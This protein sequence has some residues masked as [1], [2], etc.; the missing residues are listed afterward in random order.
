MSDSSRA[1]RRRTRRRDGCQDH[2]WQRVGAVRPAVI[3]G[4]RLW[5]HLAVIGNRVMLRSPVE[6][7]QFR[8]R[9]FR[10]VI[11]EQCMLGSMGR[12]ASAGGIAAMESFFSSLQKT[13]FNRRMWVA[14]VE[15]RLA[16][17][18]WTDRRTIVGV[19]NEGLE[20]H[21]SRVRVSVTKKWPTGC[22]NSNQAMGQLTPTNQTRSRPMCPPPEVQQPPERR[23]SS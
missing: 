20:G 19:A 8:S 7:R 22:R 23:Y 16:I 6:P 18:R 11:G 15:L 10:G 21:T 14:R 3:V 13:L 12:V 2:G 5:Q 1:S 17:I 9:A 4:E